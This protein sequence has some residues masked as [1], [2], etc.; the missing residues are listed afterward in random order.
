LW[1]LSL[2][3]IVQ[4]ISCD[5]VKFGFF[6]FWALWTGYPES[7][8]DKLNEGRWIIYSVARGLYVVPNITC[9]LYSETWDVSYML[10]QVAFH[11]SP[12]ITSNVMI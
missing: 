12:M 8:V 11:F 3:L 10:N 1:K 9:L 2:R 7:V 4:M 6:S 5:L